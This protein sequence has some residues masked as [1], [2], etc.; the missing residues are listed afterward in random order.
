MGASIGD[1]V[2]VFVQPADEN[3]LALDFLGRL[4]ADFERRR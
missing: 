4:L 2:I 3:I 1:R